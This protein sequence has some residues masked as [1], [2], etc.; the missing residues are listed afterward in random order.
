MIKINCTFCGEEIVNPLIENIPCCPK[1]KLIKEEVK[2]EQV[3]LYMIRYRN[4]E[5]GKEVTKKYQQ[6]KKFKEIQNIWHKNYYKK[7][8]EQNNQMQDVWKEN[9]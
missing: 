7:K 6:S 5:N 8:N 4:S 2:K 1:C 9:K 3:R